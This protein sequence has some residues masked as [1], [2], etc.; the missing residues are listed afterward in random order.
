MTSAKLPKPCLNALP[1]GAHS[2]IAL[3]DEALFE[4]CGVRIAFTGREGGTST[5]PYASLN[6]G[7]HVEDDLECVLRNRAIALEALG[8]PQAP[9]VVPNQVHGTEI[10]RVPD[11]SD[12]PAAAVRAKQG[13]DAVMVE[14]PGVA[15]LL[16]FADCLPL[17]IVAPDGRFAVAHAGWRGALAG[18]A[19][20]AACMLAESGWDPHGFN[21]YIGPHIRSECF[22]TSEEI[23][24]QF[25]DAYGE[26]VLAD[27]R[28]ISLAQA[29][30]VDLVRAGLSEDR[31]ADAGI[32]TVCNSDRYFSYRA[33]GGVCGRHAAIAIRKEELT[34]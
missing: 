7:D 12:A 17:I 16:N 34:C 33:A 9:L 8:F 29:V 32:C 6:T 31:I 30:T 1:M 25:A 21:A 20:K 4:V 18:I 3:T 14:A 5:G 22:E 10:V 28:H 15:A 13:A 27:K 23:A 2:V 11:A 19:G 24:R 26:D